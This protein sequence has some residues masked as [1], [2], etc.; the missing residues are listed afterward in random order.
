M[1]PADLPERVQLKK[2]LVIHDHGCESFIL[3]DCERGK[4][5]KL[6]VSEACFVLSLIESPLIAQARSAAANSRSK[7]LTDE[8]VLLVLNWL[9]FHELVDT[10]TKREPPA[11]KLGEWLASAY[12]LRIP[13]GNPQ[14]ILDRI[15]PW[16][17][18]VFHPKCLLLGA[19]FFVSMLIASLGDV[20]Q[21]QTLYQDFFSSWRWLWAL[22]AW[23]SL[24]MAHELAH[25]AACRRYGGEVRD[26]G[27]SLILFMPLAYVNVNSVW[28]LP[29]RWQRIHV[30]LAGVAI[31]LAIAGIALV[32]WNVTDSTSLRAMCADIVVLTVVSS[33]LFN[34]N[35]L[36]KFD[37][38]FVLSDLT[39]V[40]NLYSLGQSCVNYMIQRNLLGMNYD[41]PK[42]PV[43]HQWWIPTYGIATL[44]YRTSTL[45]GMIVVASYMF[46]GLGVFLAAIG[47]L[48]FIVWPVFAVVRQIWKLHSTR[49]LR[50]ARLALRLSLIAGC[51][52]GLL[53]VIPSTVDHTLPGIVEYD[54]PVT[55]R[56]TAG[57]F[58]RRL[59][60]SNGTVLAAGDIIAELEN[61]ELEREFQ[62][63]KSEK[64]LIEQ[65]ILTAQWTGDSGKLAAARDDLRA[66]ETQLHEKKAQIDELTLRAPQAGVLIA[67][68]LQV[69]M[70]TYLQPGEELAVVGLESHKRIRLSVDQFQASRG[71]EW[72]GQTVRV[73][74][75]WGPTYH[76]VAHRLE[77]RASQIPFDDSLLAVFGGSL[78]SIADVKGKFELCEPRNEAVVSL[79][80][81]QSQAFRVGQRVSVRLKNRYPSLASQCWDQMQGYLFRL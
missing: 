60:V 19:L 56:T 37:G 63:L 54:P 50:P 44:L 41:W 69:R 76:A 13:L 1:Q 81:E 77:P 2:G 32:I 24:K 29:R 5:F 16:C 25:A 52:L 75:A 21:L 48:I 7:T 3:E 23:L 10:P 49:E 80:P 30:S 31:E 67:R 65:F 57:G 62:R 9:G 59:P 34:L 71:R 58:I 12:F 72:V 45:I 36:M 20:A 15:L 6:G 46:A 39:G 43:A 4:F 22:V 33:L 78:A 55:I 28:R 11:K 47:V 66:I 14:P 8:D 27:V 51:V 68:K 38:Y 61:T 79:T 17:G 70:D 74:C 64:G 26:A 53:C 18:W 42:L 35:P 73:I 40:E